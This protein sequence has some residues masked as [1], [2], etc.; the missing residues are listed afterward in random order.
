L[1]AGAV[2]AAEPAKPETSA[3]LDKLVGQPVD[4]APWTYIW[5]ADRQV[6]EKPEAY[7]IP[8]RLKR[9][10]EVYRRIP[11][12]VP[13]HPGVSHAGEIGRFIVGPM[14]PAPTGQL[15][16]GLLWIGHVGNIKLELNW[17]GATPPVEGVEVRVY[18]RKAN[19]GWFG[20]GPDEVLDRPAISSDGH[21]WT[22]TRG[23]LP[24]KGPQ[25][26]PKH[27]ASRTWGTEMVCVFVSADAA[28]KLPGGKLPVPEARLFTPGTWDRAMPTWKRTDVAVEWLTLAPAQNVEL[29]FEGWMTKTGAAM[30]RGEQS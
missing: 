6:Q 22:Y 5:R 27:M 26:P 24:R 10:A 17:L 15:A 3:D 30:R 18:P 29:R 28:A 8:R 20:T 23:R 19:L 1:A 21:T 14:P 4:L 16:L 7:F 12:P 13:P 2:N 11:L 9:Q 25:A